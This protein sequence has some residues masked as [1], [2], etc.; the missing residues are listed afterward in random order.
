MNKKA[1]GIQWDLLILAFLIGIGIVVYYSAI[2]PIP[3]V[4]KVSLNILKTFEENSRV[5]LII[6]EIV[7]W[8]NEKTI[9]DLE[10][11]RIFNL[12]S[13]CGSGYEDRLIE[14]TPKQTLYGVFGALE[15][16]NSNCIIDEDD[17]EQYFEVIFKAEANYISEGFGDTDLGISNAEYTPFVEKEDGKYF[18]TINTVIEIPIN[19]MKDK[20]IMQDKTEKEIGKITMKPKYKLPV[21]YD[22]DDPV[23]KVCILSVDCGA[24][25]YDIMAKYP[26]V[27]QIK[28]YSCGEYFLCSDVPSDDFGKSYPCGG[29]FCG[30][31]CPDCHCT[32]WEAVGCVGPDMEYV[33]ECKLTGCDNIKKW[34]QDPCCM[35]PYPS[36][37]D[38][39]TEECCTEKD[40]SLCPIEETENEETE[41]EVTGEESDEDILVPPPPYKT[42]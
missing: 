4:G 26:G 15:N 22:F 5:P 19:I 21:D 41:E 24:D 29:Y 25:C 34:E 35:D 37:C 38:C 27:Y 7:K 33:R 14:R 20:N 39:G 1:I 23:K 42:I 16:Y 2:V 6:E 9:E 31:E 13:Y 10:E 18:N 32:S 3:K 30:E 11:N 36:K 28:D 12:K 17:I 40:P 8:S